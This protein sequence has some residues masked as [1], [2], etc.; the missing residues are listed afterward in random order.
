MLLSCYIC[1][2]EGRELRLEERENGLGICVRDTY[3]SSTPLTMSWLSQRPPRK[4]WTVP[5]RA[6]SVASG[7]SYVPA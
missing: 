1:E 5:E 3:W 7:I 4:Q 2:G 6:G